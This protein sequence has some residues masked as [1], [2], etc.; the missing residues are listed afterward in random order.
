MQQKIE[1][2]IANVYEEK[3]KEQKEQKEEEKNEIVIIWNQ[4]ILD[5]YCKGR[6]CQCAV[7]VYGNMVIATEIPSNARC[8]GYSITNSAEYAA[9]TACKRFGIAAK[10]L[11]W[12]EH[13]VLNNKTRKQM[14]KTSVDH[15]E[16]NHTLDHVTFKITEMGNIS[17]SAE[18]TWKKITGDGLIQLIADCTDDDE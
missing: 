16:E 4:Y 8:G 2:K 13:Y 17:L 3:Q 10:D 1:I 7:A 14:C 15:Q 12:I 11:V 18:P 5:Y 9:R 6:R